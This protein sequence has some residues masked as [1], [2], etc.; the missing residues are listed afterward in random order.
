MKTKIFAVLLIFLSGSF[1]FLPAVA[2]AQEQKAQLYL[3]YDFVVKPA[4]VAKFEAGVKR[5]IELGAPTP[6]S[7]FSS[8]DFH[9]YFLMAINNY[10]GIDS[11][12]KADDDWSAKI[13]KE[14]FDTLMKS[15]EGT[16]EY[17]KGGVIRYLPELSYIPKTPKFKPEE[18]NFVSWGFANIEFGKEEEFAAICK[19]WV[20][21]YDSSNI[22]MGWR[23]YVGL[24]GM[25]MP[26]YFW[27]ERSRSAAEFYADGEKMTKRVG[28]AKVTDLWNKTMAVCKK[29]ESKTGRPRSNLSNKPKGK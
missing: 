25:E 18:E 10:A 1:C 12:R 3:V 9:Y 21:L 13:G 26:F 15:Y 16:F 6:W 23:T 19:Q 4:M 27:A 8:D 22:P 28:E 24:M 11:M 14:K 2:Q 5:E 20:A 29:Y 17:Y 7:A